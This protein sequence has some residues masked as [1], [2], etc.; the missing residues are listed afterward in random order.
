M[1]FI[2]NFNDEHAPDY[3]CPRATFAVLFVW[4]KL[5]SVRLVIRCCVQPVIRLSKLPQATK[6]S[7]E[8]LKASDRAPW[9]SWPWSQWVVPGSYEQVIG[10][11]RFW[12]ILAIRRMF[13]EVYWFW[14]LT[15]FFWAWS[16]EGLEIRS[17]SHLKSIKIEIGI[18][19]QAVSTTVIVSFD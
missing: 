10:E 6:K 9:Q 7:C 5:T 17:L 15:L 12:H 4:R 18:W 13:A 2:L 1:K 14:D 3:S 11:S 8:Q 19:F 16:I